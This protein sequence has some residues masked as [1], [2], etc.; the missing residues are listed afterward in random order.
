MKCY[1]I[2]NQYFVI[3]ICELFKITKLT[4]GIKMERIYIER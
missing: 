3:L 2:N 4:N 1:I